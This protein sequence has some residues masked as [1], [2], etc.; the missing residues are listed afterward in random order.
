MAL[1]N[2]KNKFKSNNSPESLNQ[3]IE[4]SIPINSNTATGW[5]E[6]PQDYELRKQR[7]HERE[8]KRQQTYD[9]HGWIRT[10][11]ITEY[12]EGYPVEIIENEHGA[13]VIRALYEGQYNSTEVNLRE[14]LRYIKH[15]KPELLDNI[16]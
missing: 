1:E 4:F 3:D 7:E 6:S 12:C 16:E 11:E 5:Y 10:Q 14:L 13:T 2:G 15:H 8:Q 9:Q